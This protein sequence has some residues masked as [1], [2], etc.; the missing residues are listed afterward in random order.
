MTESI[1]NFGL[2]P[3]IGLDIERRVRDAEQVEAELKKEIEK[4]SVTEQERILKELRSERY[5][6]I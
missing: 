2:G 1:R 3:R 6:E 5:G 4:L